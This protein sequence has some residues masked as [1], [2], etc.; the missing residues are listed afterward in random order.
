MKHHQNVEMTKHYSNEQKKNT[1]NR[2]LI[3]PGNIFLMFF[4]S[5]LH[6]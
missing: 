5:K 3:S 4:F 6:L 1:G 2:Y